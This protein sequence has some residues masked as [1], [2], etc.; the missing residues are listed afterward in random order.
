MSK[1]NNNS[2]WVERDGKFGYLATIPMTYINYFVQNADQLLELFEMYKSESAKVA[3][4][5][6]EYKKMM[7]TMEIVL[8]FFDRVDMRGAFMPLGEFEQMIEEAPDEARQHPDFQYLVGLL[9]GRRIH[10][11]FGGI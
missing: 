3:A 6:E 9:D 10:E 5:Y 11:I 1:K 4:A 2:R 7:G 8:S